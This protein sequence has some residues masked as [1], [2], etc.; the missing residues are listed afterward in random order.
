MLVWIPKLAIIDGIVTGKLAMGATWQ[1]KHDG[2]VHI[3]DAR[4]G[5]YDVTR[6]KRDVFVAG[7]TIGNVERADT[8]NASSMTTA[9]RRCCRCAE[10][11]DPRTTHGS[12]GSSGAVSA[13]HGPSP[14]RVCLHVTRAQVGPVEPRS[15]PDRASVTS[16]S[17]MSNIAA[18]DRPE[19]GACSDVVFEIGPV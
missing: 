16:R 3:V 4:L 9:R 14:H 19:L 12:A 17:T 7:D 2:L 13:R 10:L 11:D 5:D 6:C 15:G 18:R 8:C 1:R